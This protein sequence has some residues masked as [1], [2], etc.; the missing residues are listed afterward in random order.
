MFTPEELPRAKIFACLDE[1]V[2]ARDWR[3][4][5]LICGSRRE[6]GSRTDRPS[7]CV[8]TTIVEQSR[9]G[10]LRIEQRN[11]SSVNRSRLIEARARRSKLRSAASS[12]LHI[13]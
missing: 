5:L 3:K 11:A 12:E 1:S 6:N 7:D 2:Y 9:Y 4:P 13:G 10:K 8:K